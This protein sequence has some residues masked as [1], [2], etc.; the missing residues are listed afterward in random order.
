MGGASIF[1]ESILLFV[2]FAD[3]LAIGLVSPLFNVFERDLGIS[4][5]SSAYIRAAFSF[6]QLA[7]APLVGWLCDR[8][9]TKSV[10]IACSILSGIAHLIMGASTSLPLFFSARVLLGTALQNLF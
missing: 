9:R 7:T 10:F 8:F 3:L 4:V 1:S 5:V 6:S 2:A